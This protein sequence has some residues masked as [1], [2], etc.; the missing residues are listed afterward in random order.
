[1][2]LAGDRDRALGIALGMAPW[3]R[4]WGSS[5]EDEGADEAHMMGVMEA[6]EVMEVMGEG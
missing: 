6:M 2:A 4:P 5:H 3:P 1:M